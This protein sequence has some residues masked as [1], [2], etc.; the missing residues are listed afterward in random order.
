MTAVR[1]PASRAFT[2]MSALGRFRR[3]GLPPGA[4]RWFV[5]SAAPPAPPG[6]GD[7]PDLRHL[8]NIECHRRQFRL[9][10]R[11]GVPSSAKDPVKAPHRENGEAS[12]R[13]QEQAAWTCAV[14]ASKSPTVVWV[15]ILPSRGVGTP[16]SVSAR[17]RACREVIPSAR[18][19]SIS[20]ANRCAARVAAPAAP[21][22]RR[23]RPSDH[24]ISCQ[25]PCRGRTFGSGGGCTR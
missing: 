20:S 12:G 1:P 2:R 23:A 16:R 25:S 13:T 7:Q 21:E 22:M 19:P 8:A 17:A 10:V 5:G 15:Q 14:R 9:R 4:K 18:S 3:F 11:D 6:A 24:A